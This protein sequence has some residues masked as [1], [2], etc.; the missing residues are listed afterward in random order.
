MA[1]VNEEKKYVLA[2][3]QG[4]T[5]S[6]AILFNHNGKKV[7]SSQLEIKLYFPKSGWVEQDARELFLS[8]LTVMQECVRQSKAEAYEIACIG[9]ANQRETVILWD[10]E[11]GEAV[12]HAIVWQCRRTAKMVEE[13]VSQG[14]SELIRKKTGLIPDAYF[15]ATKIKWLLDN[16]EGLRQKAEEGRILAGTVDSWLIWK[17]TGGKV[18]VTD[19]TN[20]SR[21]MLYNI[22]EKCWDKELL[23]LFNI[24]ENILPQVK[25]SSCVYGLTDKNVCGFEI[26]L[27]SCIGDQQ[28]ALFGQ[29]C[30]EEGSVKT[31]FG[32]GC[33]MLMNTGS[34]PIDSKNN[35]LTTIAIGING[36]TEYA[37]EGSVFM[38]GAVIKW[39]RDQL[40][41][42]RS[43]RE[44]DILAESVAD[45]EG[46][47]MVPAFTGL[48][49][50]YWD[51]YARGMLI[52]LTRGSS[53]A[54]ICR[55]ALEGIACQVKDVVKAMKE[56]YS[57]KLTEVKVDGG[58]CVSDVMMQFLADILDV[59]VFRPKNV[60]TTALGAA[61]CAGLAVGFW[62]SR[63]EIVNNWQIDK[64]FTSAMTAERRDKLYSR[65]MHAVERSRDWAQQS[66][67]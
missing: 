58:A 15:S 61:Y 14:K 62:K 29:A 42:I 10:K 17:L 13:L 41:I 4:T 12:Y 3:D 46:V 22:H 2:L 27:A 45:T 65:W 31:T 24:P 18:H 53:K 23:E 19:C 67:N 52:G 26:P 11:S 54:H 66:D 38:G 32:T 6:R 57:G 55:A 35:L 51:P 39:L 56:D 40:G 49:S 63:E 59:S 25:D 33:F 36:K 28:A 37:L 8:Q 1:Q 21:T 50:P 5:S 16:V 43:A 48:G 9:I 60:E 47:V 34:I 7:S 20:A 64:I 30:F 44:C